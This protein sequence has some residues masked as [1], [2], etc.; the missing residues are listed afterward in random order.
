M[1]TVRR[2]LLFLPQL[3][4]VIAIVFL[5]VQ[6]LPGDPV[7][8]MAGP[9]AT[10][11][12]RDEIRH[13]WGQD[14]PLVTQYVNYMARLLRGDLGDSWRTL[15]PV[16]ADLARRF[17]ATMEL[18]ICTVVIAIVVG[19]P[20]GIHIAT[21]PRGVLSRVLFLYGMVAGAVPDFWLAL[22]VIYV[23]F[24][25]F[26]LIGAP[27]GRLDIA[28]GPPTTISGMYVL[29]SLLT[30]NWATL[31][32]SISHLVGPVLTLALVYTP[33]VIKNT[34]SAVTEVLASDYI[35]YARAAGLSRMTQMRYILRNALPPV[36]TILGLCFMF[37]L[38]GCV[39]VETVFGW[40]GIG[41]YAVQAVATSDYRPLQGFVLLGGAYTGLIFLV[42]D[43]VN[44]ALDPRQRI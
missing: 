15:R 32:S 24:V 10:E 9:Y 8:L 6:L 12:R 30:R 34:G 17:P 29:D 43:L 13:T 35:L 38:G 16:T 31:K 5:M 3:L 22:I 37:L 18:I 42:V 21:N 1:Y 14:Q 2:L 7:Y 25:R 4:V 39:L 26:R 11:A 20:I 23:L 40:A 33:M 36:I 27:M 41:Q 28:I 44:R 19:I